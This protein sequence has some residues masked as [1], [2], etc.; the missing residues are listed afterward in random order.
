MRRA[1]PRRGDAARERAVGD[2]WN[3]AVVARAVK[4]PE[5]ETIPSDDFKPEELKFRDIVSL[6]VTQILQTYGDKE[7]KDNAPV[8]EGVIDDLVGGPIFLALYPYFRRYGGVFK[9]SL[10]HI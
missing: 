3:R 6:W 4:E 10:I 8:C 9:L 7:S 1:T 2:A 5:E